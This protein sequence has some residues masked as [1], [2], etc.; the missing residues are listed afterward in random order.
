MATRFVLNI[1]WLD[2]K[3]AKAMVKDIVDKMD[4]RQCSYPPDFVAMPSSSSHT[5]V[6][7][8]MLQNFKEWLSP[9]DPSTNYAIGLRDLHEETATWFLEGRI[10]REWHST[11]SL[12]WIHGKR[13][14]VETRHFTCP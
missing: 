4:A 13:M 8:E 12:L 3:Q 5:A 9:P 10:F 14:F 6:G 7:K 2:V 1:F 11:G